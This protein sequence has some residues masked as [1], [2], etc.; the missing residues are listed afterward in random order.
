MPWKANIDSRVDLPGVL[1]A[2]EISL[3]YRDT[4]SVSQV[5]IYRRRMSVVPVSK[6]VKVSSTAG[7]TRHQRDGFSW[8]R[9]YRAC[10]QNDGPGRLYP[11]AFR[12]P[13]GLSFWHPQ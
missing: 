4:L 13:F 12:F 5:Y 7:L 11:Q 6:L 9:N 3:Q 2:A 10:S 8:A 1:C